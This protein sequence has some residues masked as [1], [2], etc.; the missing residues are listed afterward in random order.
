MRPVWRFLATLAG[1]LLVQV[2]AF[3]V[4]ARA[5]EFAASGTA[6]T[7]VI[8][9]AAATLRDCC[10]VDDAGRLWFTLP[11]GASYELIT[12]NT[13]PD[14][15]NPGDGSFHPFDA[16]EVRAA[17]SGMRFPLGAIA[18]DVYLLPYPRRVQVE[19][20][21]GHGL[22]LLSPGVRPL[23]SEH[24]HAEFA[25]ELGHV[26]QYAL[27]PDDDVRWVAYR[28]LRG[29]TDP[30][31]YS[32]SSP[33]ADRP[34]E[35]FA[36]DFRALFGDAAANY[37]GTIENDALTP[38]AQVAGLELFLL[39]LARDGAPTFTASPNPSHGILTL[40][41]GHAPPVPLDLIDLSGRRI[42][43]LVPRR[44]GDGVMW[45][46]GGRDE[47]GRPVPP[48]VLYAKPR[49]IVGAAT[50]VVLLP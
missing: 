42:G 37:S 12:S 47:M 50:R 35:I 26:V 33:H 31:H 24:Q 41:L 48:G 43:T 29:I 45:T 39:G 27:M 1:G 44:I 49:G 11:G 4:S 5:D 25:H 28:S 32:A 36:E 14:I 40:S 7:L 19:S 21:A 18:A 23:S 34:H 20:A 38:P 3:G 8:H 6:R 2:A 10:A 15:V 9:D 22:I 16:E 17:L 30:V 46:F 13:D